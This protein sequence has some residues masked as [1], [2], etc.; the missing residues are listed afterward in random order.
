MVH[1]NNVLTQVDSLT[2]PSLERRRDALKECI[3]SDTFE[4]ELDRR[5]K[6]SELKYIDAYLRV[7]KKVLS[8]GEK[9]QVD[10]CGEYDYDRENDILDEISD[11]MAELKT[12][13]RE[14]CQCKSECSS[15]KSST[16]HLENAA[17]ATTGAGVATTPSA[18]AKTTL[19]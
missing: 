14:V 10:G 13:E 18:T 7:M 1:P 11:D 8:I 4:D 5:L 15:R 19:I 12:A 6:T 16:V 3:T 2:I 9:C 17:T